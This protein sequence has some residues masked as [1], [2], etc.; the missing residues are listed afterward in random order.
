MTKPE[1]KLPRRHFHGLLRRW[2]MA[3]LSVLA[4]MCGTATAKDALPHVSIAVGGVTCICYLPIVLAGQLGEYEKA[5]VDTEIVNFRGGSQAL[6]AVLGGSADVVMGYF[7]HCVILAAQKQN[8]QAF[9]MFD[10]FPGLVLVVA[11]SRTGTINSVKDLAGK[12]VGVTAPGSSTDFFLKFLLHKNGVDVNSVS[13]TGIG[14]DA[15]A[16]AAQEQGRIDAAMMNDPS[17]TVLEQKYKDLKILS[18]TRTAAD[19]LGVF[20]SEYPSGVLYARADWIA[21]H[22]AQVQALTTAVVASLR[23][24][25]AHSAEDIMARMPPEMVGPDKQLYLAALRKTMP[26]FSDTA[27]MDAKGARAVVEVLSQSVPAVASAH[28]AV[29]DIFTNRFVEQAN[30]KLG[31]G[32]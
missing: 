24:I 16:V 28:I 2:M 31:G 21:K 14:L 17:V 32:R 26:M 18:D 20:G 11:P 29:T 10:R 30:A 12:I 1:S 6:T 15:T 23:W 27:L 7:D 3:P 9:V 19:T 5:G 4:L 22:E 13:V 25:H 8:M